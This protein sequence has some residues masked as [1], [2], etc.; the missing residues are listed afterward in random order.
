[1]GASSWFSLASGHPALQPPERGRDRGTRKTRK[2]C[3]L[4]TT[5]SL[6]QSL[7]EQV[8]IDTHTD[9]SLITLSMLQ[10]ERSQTELVNYS[11]VW[12]QEDAQRLL[13]LSV[14]VV[15]SV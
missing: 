10:Y 8:I 3:K 7:S 4:L 12:I 11:R 2:E 13:L 15:S 1:M 9:W 6:Q 14:S 5:L